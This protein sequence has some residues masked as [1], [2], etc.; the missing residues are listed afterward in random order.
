MD[1]RPGQRHHPHA[2]Y[3]VERQ[4]DLRRLQRTRAGSRDRDHQPVLGVLEPS[5]PLRGHRTGTRTRFRTRHRRPARCPSRCLRLGV[6]LSWH[7]RRRRLPQ[8][9]LR[10]PHRGGRGARV[11]DDAGERLRRSQHPGHRR[12]ARAAHPKRD[13]HRRCRRR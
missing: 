10:Q 6:R 7:A 12:Q 1:P 5:R 9:H 3:R 4:G 13:E 8:G 11:S 2:G